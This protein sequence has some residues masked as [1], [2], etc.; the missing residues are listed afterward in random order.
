M[1]LSAVLAEGGFTPSVA[2]RQDIQ[3]VV[4]GADGNWA[5]RYVMGFAIAREDPCIRAEEGHS[6]GVGVSDNVLPIA[7][8]VCY[9]SMVLP[10]R[11]SAT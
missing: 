3:R 9:L 8:D 6:E 4:D 2:A 11:R 5:G 10:F 1:A 7:D